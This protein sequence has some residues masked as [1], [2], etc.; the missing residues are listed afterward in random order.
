MGPEIGLNKNHQ[1]GDILVNDSE[2]KSKSVDDWPCRF[3][4]EGL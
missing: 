3:T 1:R 4:R 2:S